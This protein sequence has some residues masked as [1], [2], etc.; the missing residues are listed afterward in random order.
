MSLP[1]EMI[2]IAD[3]D[4]LPDDHPMRIKAI[5]LNGVL[6]GE[7]SAKSVVG[8]WARA[9]KVYC[10]YIGEPLVSDVAVETGAKLINALSGISKCTKQ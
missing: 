3:R 4:R 5:E 7:A 8:A 6:A 2:Q 1:D 10:E 9:R